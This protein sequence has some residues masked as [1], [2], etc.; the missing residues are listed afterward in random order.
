[1]KPVPALVLFLCL[2][3]PVAFADDPAPVA[4]VAPKRAKPMEPRKFAAGK[5]TDP[6]WGITYE[7]AGLEEKPGERPVGQLL[8]A[9]SGRVQI[10]IGVWEYADQ[11]S[12]TQRRDAVKKGWDERHHELKDYAQGDDPF[13]WAPFQEEA[14]S[15]G[16]RRHGYAWYARGCRAFVVH[17]YVMADAPGGAESVKAAL[18]GLVVG[19]ETGA[20]LCVQAV[21][22]QREMPMCNAMS[23]VATSSSSNGSVMWVK[24]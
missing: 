21:S 20:T 23:R 13:A 14:P 7:F 12:P 15:G 11:L 1:M 19:P 4:P 3:A 6:Y 22:K 16:M 2:A 8:L 17:S 5:L 24:C 18:A 10:E 9:K